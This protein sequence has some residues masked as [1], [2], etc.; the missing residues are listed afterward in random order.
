VLELCLSEDDLQR[1]AARA[2]HRRAQGFA[3]E[4]LDTAGVRRSEPRA[5][6]AARGGLLFPDDTRIDPVLFVRALAAS[7]RARGAEVVPGVEV[8]EFE[9]A[10]ERIARVRAGGE[11]LTPGAVVLAAGAWA[12]RLG[13]VP[14]VDVRPARGQML[15]LHAGRDFV[16]RVLSYADG[17][18]VPCRNG[19]LLVGATV[20]DTGFTKA[21]TPAGVSALLTKL[22]A[23][24][25]GA[26]DTPITRLWS[27]LRP[28]APAGPVIGPAP[29]AAN[30]VLAC[31]H[32]RN[33]IL[34][35]PITA[36]A[37][38]AYLD[39]TPPPPE[40]REFLPRGG[41]AA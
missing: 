30:V 5:N 35:A 23:L 40:A 18:V 34:L 33:G 25:P 4:S 1:A 22:D 38:S 36:Q 3:V 2:A 29:G 37:V 27:G 26:R 8:S 12:T 28:Y 21:V 20:E 7:A 15:A 39:G 31:G 41:A 6:P 17:Y 24:V 11:W 9:R 10:G 14:R 16:R 19:E 13:I 32:F